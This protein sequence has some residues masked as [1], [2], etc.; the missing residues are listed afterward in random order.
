MKVKTVRQRGREVRAEIQNNDFQEAT[1]Q[2]SG[3][4]ILQ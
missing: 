1:D 4:K 3:P 2:S